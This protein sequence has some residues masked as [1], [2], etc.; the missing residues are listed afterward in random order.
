MLYYKTP[1][2]FVYEQ[3]ADF[4]TPAHKRKAASRGWKPTTKAEYD[5]YIGK[6]PTK[7][8]KQSN[9]EIIESIGEA[10][11]VDQVDALIKGNRNA[12]VKAA[13]LEKI[14]ELK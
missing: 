8:A 10:E 1:E 12:K 6:K 2:G 3:G 4:D 7:K 11:T 14:N 5:A 13:A 9:E